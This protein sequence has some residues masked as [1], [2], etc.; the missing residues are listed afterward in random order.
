MH[1]FLLCILDPQPVQL[2]KFASN[3]WS[4]LKF[5]ISATRNHKDLGMGAVERVGNECGDSM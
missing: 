3:A 5:A 1:G 4:S 2:N